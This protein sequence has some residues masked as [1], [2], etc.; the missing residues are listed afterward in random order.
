M[1]QVLLVIS[2]GLFAACGSGGNKS[3]TSDSMLA[4]PPDT[5]NAVTPHLPDTATLLK[6]R[7]HMMGDTSSMRKDTPM[8]H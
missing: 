5:S 4:A 2:I 8:L 1:K 6:D 3:T 7:N